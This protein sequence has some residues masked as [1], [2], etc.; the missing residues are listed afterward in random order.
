MI[1]TGGIILGVLLLIVTFVL[2]D[3]KKITGK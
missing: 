1:W 3:I 2:L